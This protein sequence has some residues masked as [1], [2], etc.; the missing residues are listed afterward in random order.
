MET[1]IIKLE[2]AFAWTC[3]ECGERHLMEGVIAELNAYERIEMA[4]DHGI[5]SE[6][7]GEWITAPATVTCEE[8]DSYYRVEGTVATGEEKE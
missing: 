8:C 4:E 5:D 6:Q 3:P 1:P 2:P 7:T